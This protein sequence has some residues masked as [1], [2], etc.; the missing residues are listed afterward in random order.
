MMGLSQ[1]QLVGEEVL[2][3]RRDRAIPRVIKR[4]MGPW[5]KK[6]PKDREHPQSTKKFRQSVMILN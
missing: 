1:P 3:P 2:E 4:K 6:R 5:L